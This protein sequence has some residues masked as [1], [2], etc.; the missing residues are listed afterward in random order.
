MKFSKQREMIYNQVMNFPV[1]PT[2]D[3]VY[4]ALKA[5]NPNLSLGTV[6]RNLNQLSELGMLLK[7]RIADGSDRFDGRTD[8]HYHMVCDKC[9]QVFDVE[10]SELDSL[11]D[12]VAEKYGHQLTIVT[13]NLN[14]ICCDCRKNEQN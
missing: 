9:T 10:L 5:D 4:T 8:A 6:Y 3:Q 11:N 7:I 1:H 14:G 2:A 13:L 12:I